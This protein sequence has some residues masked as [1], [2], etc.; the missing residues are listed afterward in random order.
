MYFKSMANLS[1]VFQQNLLKSY[2]NSS[3]YRN[4]RNKSNVHNNT[5]N[6]FTNHNSSYGLSLTYIPT[7]EA[8]NI[9]YN[10]D[11]PVDKCCGG[12]ILFINDLP[13]SFVKTH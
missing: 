9:Y 5:F 3:N 2:S 13:D 8:N 1:E 11:M 12:N 7:Y 6:I 10:S 4:S